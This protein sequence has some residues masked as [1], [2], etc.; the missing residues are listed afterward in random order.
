M[1]STLGQ[2][3]ARTV[4]I[5][6]G[7]ISLQDMDRLRVLSLKVP[8]TWEQGGSIQALPCHRIAL[9]VPRLTK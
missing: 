4:I 1:L 3:A 6:L 7:Q 8:D 5:Y 9:P 2:A